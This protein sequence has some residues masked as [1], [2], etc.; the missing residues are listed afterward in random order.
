MHLSDLSSDKDDRSLI[1]KVGTGK[2]TGGEFN[3][4]SQAS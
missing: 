3:L 4:T 2:V 1:L